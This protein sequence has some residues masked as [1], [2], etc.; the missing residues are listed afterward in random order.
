MYD[1]RSQ[2][3]SRSFA[4]ETSLILDQQSF[5]I[6]RRPRRCCCCSLDCCCSCECSRSSMFFTDSFLNFPLSTRAHSYLRITCLVNTPNKC[7]ANLLF[8]S[9]PTKWLKNKDDLWIRG[10]V[11]FYVFNEWS[12]NSLSPY[13]MTVN[14][15][16]VLTIVLSGFCLHGCPATPRYVEATQ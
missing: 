8:S 1:K 14:Q 5:F 16:W 2:R 13:K 12:Q 3:S 15:G 6:V 11:S 9:I 10:F 4:H 7:C